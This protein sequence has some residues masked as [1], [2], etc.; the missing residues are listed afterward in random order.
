MCGI[1]RSIP[2]MMDGQKYLRGEVLRRA[3]HGVGGVVFDFLG[4]AP[5]DDLR[6][7][8]VHSYAMRLYLSLSLFLSDSMN[9][10]PS[11]PLPLCEDCSALRRLSLSLSLE[12]AV[13]WQRSAQS[14]GSSVSQLARFLFSFLLSFFSF[15]SFSGGELAHLEV[16]LGGD[17]E[18]LGFQVS[19]DDVHGVN[20]LVHRHHL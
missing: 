3:A 9:I 8:S 19:V 5:V 16:T 2:N 11:L 18:V 10:P 6:E 20:V 7:G 15:L 4:K 13:C 14:R 17:Q 1:L 12:R